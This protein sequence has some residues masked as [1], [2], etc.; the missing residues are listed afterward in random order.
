M[1]G[2][3]ESTGGARVNVRGLNKMAMEM[4]MEM[5]MKMEKIE[6]DDR[7]RDWSI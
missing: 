2:Y 6:S 3:C 5:E 7:N 4:A 1:S